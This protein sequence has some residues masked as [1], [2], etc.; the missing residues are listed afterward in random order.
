[1]QT[2]FS[3]D[4]RVDGVQLSS[5]GCPKTKCRESAVEKRCR[6][7]TKVCPQSFREAQMRVNGDSF[8]RE[9]ASKQIAVLGPQLVR[10][11]AGRHGD[12]SK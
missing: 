10:E 9:T 8:L 3:G 4:R 12:W 7:R 2:M 6:T 11:R 1:M 5:W